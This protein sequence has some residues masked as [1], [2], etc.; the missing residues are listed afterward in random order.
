MNKGPIT[1]RHVYVPKG[2][3]LS[4]IRF[5]GLSFI[6]LSFEKIIGKWFEA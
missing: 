3:C 5:E 1:G 2:T 4:G 6:I